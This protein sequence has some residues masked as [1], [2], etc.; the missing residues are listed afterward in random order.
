MTISPAVELAQVQARP[1]TKVPEIGQKIDH[2]LLVTGMALARDHTVHHQRSFDPI[3]PLF[4][5][6]GAKL[7]WLVVGVDPL[8]AGFALA[9]GTM[10]VLVEDVL[11]RPLLL[12][13]AP[14]QESVRQNAGAAAPATDGFMQWFEHVFS[15]FQLKHGLRIATRWLPSFTGVNR[16]KPRGITRPAQTE[17]SGVR[18]VG[19]TA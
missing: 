5:V 8:Q 9:I 12:G 18:K 17:R 16:V 1:V 11:D 6:H 14:F 19:D 10:R 3:G 15:P 13:D 7:L 4:I 2:V